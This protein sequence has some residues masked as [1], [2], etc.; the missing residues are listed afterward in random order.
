VKTKTSPKTN[1][2]IANRVAG[3]CSASLPNGGRDVSVKRGCP[4]IVKL[5]R[6][7]INRDN[8]VSKEPTNTLLGMGFS[9]FNKPTPTNLSQPSTRSLP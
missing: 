5:T 9:L 7:A 1:N 3:G 4:K 2:V 6:K 8:I